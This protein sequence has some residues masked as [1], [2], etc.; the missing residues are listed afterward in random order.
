MGAIGF[1][2]EIERARTDALPVRE[3]HGRVW[4]WIELQIRRSCKARQANRLVLDEYLGSIAYD[5][6]EGDRQWERSD[7]SISF[8]FS[9]AAGCCN[10]SSDAAYHWSRLIF[11][12]DRDWLERGVA[13]PTGWRIVG[14][15]EPWQ[16][17]LRAGPSSPIVYVKRGLYFSELRKPGARLEDAEDLLW[18]DEGV[19]R[20]RFAELSAG[21][22]VIVEWA[23]MTG[24]CQ[25]DLCV[26][27]GKKDRSYLKPAD[28]IERVR[29]AWDL[30][31]G[32]ADAGELERAAFEA[33]RDHASWREQPRGPAELQVLADRV[34]ERA[35]GLALPALVGLVRVRGRSR[36]RGY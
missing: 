16:E 17:V 33:L 31:E 19:R 34:E 8:F 5:G 24:L 7:K 1:S 14:Q 11:A 4:E 22:R 36:T 35:G 18:S 23:A 21:E 27:L 2:V 29:A 12:E 15:A 3:L 28:G 25:C 9:D 10:A 32:D 30:L 6:L 20:A 26:R 13:S